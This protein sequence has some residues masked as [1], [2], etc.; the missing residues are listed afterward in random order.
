VPAPRPPQ[1]SL[2]P[3]TSCRQQLSPEMFHAQSYAWKSTKPAVV[4]RRTWKAPSAPQQTMCG[5]KRSRALH[6]TG[7]R[8]GI[9][10][11]GASR[12]GTNAY[13]NGM[14]VRCR[15]KNINK[16]SCGVYVHVCTRVPGGYG[17]EESY[18]TRWGEGVNEE[19]P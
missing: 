5:Q 7:I 15:L 8:V 6:A 4:G 9:W 17:G 13:S 2:P 10:K 19:G 1:T 12:A 11:G 14:C 3:G 16:M 18:Q